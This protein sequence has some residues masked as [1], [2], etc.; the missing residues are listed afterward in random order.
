MRTTRCAYFSR[1]GRTKR[2][3][4]PGDV[5]LGRV[6][7]HP[8]MFRRFKCVCGRRDYDAKPIRLSTGFWARIVALRRS[9]FKS[10]VLLLGGVEQEGSGRLLHKLEIV[11][12]H[13]EALEGG[14]AQAE[15]HLGAVAADVD[16]V[17][18][19]VDNACA[20]VKGGFGGGLR[21]RFLASGHRAHPCLEIAERISSHRTSDPNWRRRRVWRCRR[22]RSGSLLKWSSIASMMPFFMFQHAGQ[23]TCGASG[24]ISR[25]R[26]GQSYRELPSSISALRTNFDQQVVYYYLRAP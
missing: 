26:D 13:A 1:N 4:R 10:G 23:K 18:T 8:Q 12:R 5:A 21:P 7:L 25:S 3:D 19:F 24:H 15:V 11:D 20:D 6:T 22:V 14:A 17:G 16:G 9:I 2:A